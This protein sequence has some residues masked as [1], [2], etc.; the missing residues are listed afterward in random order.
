MII[1][2]NDLILAGFWAIYQFDYIPIGNLAGHWW[3]YRVK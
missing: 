1:I 2:F 3:R